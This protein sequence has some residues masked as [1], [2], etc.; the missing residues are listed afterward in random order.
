MSAWGLCGHG[1]E[2]LAKAT[3]PDAWTSRRYPLQT[4][5]QLELA[6]RSSLALSLRLDCFLDMLADFGVVMA[7]SDS[8]VSRVMPRHVAHSLVKPLATTTGPEGAVP[9]FSYPAFCEAM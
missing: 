3:A 9:G 4:T 8:T 5:W 2:G 6:D 1:V 7:T